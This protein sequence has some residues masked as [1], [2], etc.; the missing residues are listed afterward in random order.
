MIDLL[1]FCKCFSWRASDT[2]HASFINTGTVVLSQLSTALGDPMNNLPLSSRIYFED[3]TLKRLASDVQ[4][5]EA[6][7]QLLC[8]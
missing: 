2:H 5:V 3:N 8:S 7:R 4:H 1:P 6:L